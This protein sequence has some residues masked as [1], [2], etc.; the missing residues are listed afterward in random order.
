M[1]KCTTVLIRA[2][3]VAVASLM[4]AG[5]PCFS[6][7]LEGS[8]LCP[9][10]QAERARTPQTK[11]GGP[12]LQVTANVETGS[13][14]KS[15]YVSPDGSL[16][17]SCN[18]GRPDRDNI[19]V[20]NA[21][22]LE[23]VGVIEFRGNCVEL[24]FSP[25]GATMY[26][27]NFRRGVVEVIDVASRTVRGEIEVGRNPKTI[28][29]SPDGSTLYVAN[30]FTRSVSVVNVASM[31]E[32]GRIRTGHLPRGMALTDDGHL[33]VAA[34]DDHIIHDFDTGDGNR[35]VR[36]IHTC[37]FPRSLRLSPDDQRLYVSCSCCRRIQW[38]D[39]GSGRLVAMGATGENP[40]SIDISTDGRYVAVADFD[41]S[42]VSLI[43]T[44]AMVSR[45]NA[46]RGADRIVGV[47][48]RPGPN[49]RVYATS[50][51]T[52]HLYA[53]DPRP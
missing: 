39:L 22:T 42:T 11:R 46:V 28:V 9:V 29:V 25:D 51:N 24:A 50:W 37:R 47:A 1:A 33:Y 16:V 13:Q 8:P 36:Q 53:L 19:R 30:Y 15:V 18:F 10:A 34:F 31:A 27:S 7:R 32:T 20:Y 5:P 26:A 45:V 43:D 52:S 12:V 48:I 17:F 2:V 44:V 35:E 6:E 14:P 41:T 49:L 21:D 40:R 4:V 3:L 38:H 23:Q